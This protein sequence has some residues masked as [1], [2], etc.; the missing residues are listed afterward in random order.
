MKFDGVNYDS[1]K[2]EKKI[3]EGMK[4]FVCCTCK[5]FGHFSSKFPKRVKK[6]KPRE[7]YKS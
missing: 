1:W 5:D 6:T 7:P 2:E 4:S 3:D